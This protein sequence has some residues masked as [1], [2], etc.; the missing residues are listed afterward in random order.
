MLTLKLN[1][2]INF[3]QHTVEDGAE[4]NEARHGAD[5]GYAALWLPGSCC[6]FVVAC[7]FLHI[8]GHCLVYDRHP[9]QRVS[10]WEV[11]EGAAALL[12]WMDA[13]TTTMREKRVAH[14]LQRRS[15]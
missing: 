13:H 5:D 10:C 9:R 6:V 11:S 14:S 4:R 7:C 1:R 8:C 2:K 3:K 15:Q 12:T